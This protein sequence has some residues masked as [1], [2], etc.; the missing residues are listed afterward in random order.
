LLGALL[1]FVATAARARP[2]AEDYVLHCMGCHGAAGDGE[3]GG[4]PSLRGVD[5]FLRV[6]GGRAYLARVP[7]VAQ[8]ALDDAAL[9]RLLDWLVAHF[10]ETKPARRPRYSASE[11]QR[12]RALPL[13]DPLRVRRALLQ[14]LDRLDAVD[15]KGHVD[16]AACHD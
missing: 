16:G 4:V 7:G 1:T 2:P 5:R 13:A 14:R 15:S 3:R 11:I 10:G 6:E 12:L 9:A 8:A